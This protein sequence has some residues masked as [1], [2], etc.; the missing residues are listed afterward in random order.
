MRILPLSLMRGQASASK[1]KQVTPLKNYDGVALVWSGTG[2]ILCS[3][4][5]PVS[6]LFPL[7]PLYIHF[8]FINKKVDGA[9]V[10]PI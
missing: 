3:F 7:I 9:R 2:E 10:I 1:T 4:K 5:Y 6:T 8:N